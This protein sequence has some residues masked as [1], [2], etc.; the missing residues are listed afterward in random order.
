M[1]DYMQHGG[2]GQQLIKHYGQR[3]HLMAQEVIKSATS[4]TAGGSLLVLSGLTL[5]GTVIALIMATPLLVI[6]SPVLVPTVITAFLLVA[7]FLASGVF[8]IAGLSTLAWIY[9]LMMGGRLPGEDELEMDR[10]KLKGRDVKDTAQYYGQQAM[11]GV[12]HHTSTA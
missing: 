12:H 1:A 5:T 9:R 3:Q 4:A 10:M 6:F 8:G 11:G 2:Q 7:G